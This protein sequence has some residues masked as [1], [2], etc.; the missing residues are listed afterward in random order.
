MS[1]NLYELRK[2]MLKLKK[3]C[4]SKSLQ[5]LRIQG[6]LVA[7]QRK[8]KNAIYSKIEVNFQPWVNV[9]PHANY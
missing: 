8:I 6:G 2:C 1:L 7:G 4:S 5:S 3:K 9:I